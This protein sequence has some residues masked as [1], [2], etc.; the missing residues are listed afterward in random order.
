MHSGPCRDARSHSKATEPSKDQESQ[1]RSG[2]SLSVRTH[3]YSGLI[4]PK[5]SVGVRE[6]PILSFRS[7]HGPRWGS[8]LVRFVRRDVR[9]SSVLV[10]PLHRWRRNAFIK[11]IAV[12]GFGGRD[13]RT[14]GPVV[15]PA[16]STY[17]QIFV[18]GPACMC[19]C[20][21][22]LIVVVAGAKR[23]FRRD[24]VQQSSAS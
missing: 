13:P 10:G 1:P 2:P 14:S 11:P 4:R 15:N 18:S 17:N 3:R 24:A 20:V 12:I 19:V 23:L 16:S 6:T 5:H 22:I 9:A 21:C 8:S 7:V